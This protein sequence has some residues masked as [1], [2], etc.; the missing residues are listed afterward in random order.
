[1]SSDAMSGAYQG[2]SKESYGSIRLLQNQ[3]PGIRKLARGM[4]PESENNA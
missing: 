4:S 1:M 2:K 3:I